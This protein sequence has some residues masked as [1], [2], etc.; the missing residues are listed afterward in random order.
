MDIKRET[1]KIIDIAHQKAGSVIEKASK[2]DGKGSLQQVGVLWQQQ[3]LHT[4]LS[5]HL[6]CYQLL[7]GGY[8][9]IH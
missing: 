9:L 2:S 4:G 3:L 5:A 7:H 8:Q 6:R 1:E